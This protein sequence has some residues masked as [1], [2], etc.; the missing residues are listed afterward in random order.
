MAEKDAIEQLESLPESL[1]EMKLPEEGLPDNLKQW[2]G[3]SVA[4]ILKSYN[5]AQSSLTKAYQDKSTAQ[6]LVKE[7]ETKNM[8]Y[9]ERLQELTQQTT[10]EEVV[11]DTTD[12]EYEYL[13]KGEMKKMLKELN[14]PTTTDEKKG[15][16]KDEIVELVRGERIIGRFQ[17]EHP[18]YN[19]S[20]INAIIQVGIAYN[21]KDLNE[22][23]EK[24]LELAGKS[25]LKK[26]ESKEKPVPSQVSGVNVD[27][28]TKE[29]L[30]KKFIKVGNRGS[31]SDIL[32]PVR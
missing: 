27:P 13:T 2:S 1:K 9:E 5:E 7:L 28:D 18:E 8:S 10:Q 26:S 11:D 6:A 24:F 19:D 4:D 3:K 32:T 15:L 30:H 29:P 20:D 14:K 22:A 31:F 21:A 16:D 12:D 25:G 23:N 17:D